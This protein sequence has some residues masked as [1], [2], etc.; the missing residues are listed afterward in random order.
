MR[1]KLLRRATTAFSCWA[2]DQLTTQICKHHRRR[3]GRIGWEHAIDPPAGGWAGSAPVRQG[4]AVEVLIDG[5][6]AL[7]RIAD[8]LRAAKSHV[9]LTGWYFSPD[10]ALERDG[11]PTIL[12]NLLAELAERIDVRCSSGRARRSRSSAR[13]AATCGRCASG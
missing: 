11:P 7:P 8:E 1:T 5:A 13:R 2:G 3:L 10:F 4:N 6:E 9:H 12:R